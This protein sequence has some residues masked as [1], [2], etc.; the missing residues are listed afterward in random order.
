MQR[1]HIYSLKAFVKRNF[2]DDDD[3]DMMIKKRESLGSRFLINAISTLQN[4]IYKWT[5]S[6]MYEKATQICKLM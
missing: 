2:S 4:V 6:F 1:I 3:F 5:L